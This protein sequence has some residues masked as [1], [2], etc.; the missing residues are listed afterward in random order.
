[1]TY[2]KTTY[3]TDIGIK[4][5]VGDVTLEVHICNNCGGALGIDASFIEQV[6]E[7]ILCPMCD[8]G[9]RILLANPPDF[10]KT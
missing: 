4:T 7:D 2:I 5:S 6:Q 3:V 10:I 1:M 9:T 8:N